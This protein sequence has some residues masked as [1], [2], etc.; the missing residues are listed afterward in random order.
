MESINFDMLKEEDLYNEEIYKKIYNIQ[1]APERAKKEQELFKVAKG[2]K[3]GGAIKSLYNN[4]VKENKI[5][6][7]TE[8]VIDFGEGA[9]IRQMY[10]PGYFKD[11][12]GFIRTRD[13]NTL[14]TS[15]ILEPIAVYKNCES[16]EE[17]V[18]CAFRNKNN[19]WGTFIVNRETLVNSGKI[20]RLANKGVDVTSESSSVLI[21]YIRDLLNNNVIKELESTSK[22]GWHDKEF[23]PYD[24]SI[25]FDGEDSFRTAFESLSEKGSFD[26]WYQEVARLRKNNTILKMTMGTSFASP[27]LY[28][29]HKQSFVFLLWGKTGGKKTVAGRIAMSIWG[30]SEKG[31]LMFSMDSTSNFYYRTASF[32]NHIPVFFDEL[33]TFNGDINRLI[34]ILTEGIDR[35][36][37]K[38]DGGIEQSR[39]WNNTFILTGEHSASD[40]NSGG[41]TL[42]RLIE[43]YIKN[44]IVE[45]GIG[46]C[47]VL[48]DNYGF[49]GKIFIDYIK[50]IGVEKLQ[51]LFKEKYDSL[52]ALDTTEEK[53]AINMAMIMLADDLACKCI[54]KDEEP[55]KAEDVV[56]YMFS[57]QSIDN[58]ER[59]YDV[60]LQECSINKR[61]FVVKKDGTTP[62]EPYNSEF[63]GVMNEYEICIV[64][65]KLRDLLKNNGFN[66]TKAIKDWAIK[67]YVEKFSNDRYSMSLSKE[68]IKANYTVIKIVDREEK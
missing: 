27:L 7:S 35:G 22:M 42:N 38:V 24:S 4:Y 62:H 14:V 47:N 37:A 44:D 39:T 17:L 10:A 48:N 15:T 64:N 28:L 23:L 52:M 53:Q 61:Y 11:S 31:K 40:I 21:R 16:G 50:E 41:G 13:K 51:Q 67:G 5:K 59:A 57:K 54:F 58:S 45:D 30:N 20:T 56:P 29:L 9:P 19:K 25:E 60:I 3:I 32:F 55:L 63:W 36:K 66:Y 12:N 34:M 68:G 2:Y 1:S 33:Q 8:S 18:K 6:E 46:I 26:K 49:A 43:V 65:K